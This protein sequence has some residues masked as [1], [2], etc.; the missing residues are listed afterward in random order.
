MLIDDLI[1]FPYEQNEGESYRTM[2]NKLMEAIRSMKEGITEVTL[3]PGL[4]TPE[5]Q[6]ITPHGR[7]REFEHQLFKD[8]EIKE[9]IQREKITITSWMEIRDRQRLRKGK[10]LK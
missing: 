1:T 5:M 7:K 3:H 4:N 2:K 6:A 10:S 8:S 9:L